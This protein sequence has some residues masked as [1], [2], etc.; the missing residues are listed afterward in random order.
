MLRAVDLS[1]RMG[2]LITN[3]LTD[4][5]QIIF[6]C[7]L[8]ESVPRF[9]KSHADML[10]GYFR[11]FVVES[12][13]LDAPKIMNSNASGAGLGHG[14]AFSN[15]T[16]AMTAAELDLAKLEE[17]V[18]ADTGC[19]VSLVDREWRSQQAPETPVSKIASP[20]RVRGVGASHHETSEFITQR[21]YPPA[22]D[23]NGKSILACLYR[24]LHIVNNLRAKMLIGNDIIGPEGIVI[25]V[26]N[27]QARIGSCN[28][29]AKITPKPRG[30]Y[31]RRKILA[32]N[33]ALVPPRTEMM[34]PTKAVNLPPDRDFIFEPVK[35]ANLTM[36][37]T[38]WTM[39][40]C[41]LATCCIMRVCLNLLQHCWQIM[42][43]YP[44]FQ[45]ILHRIPR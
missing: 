18:R 2:I 16:Y 41:T 35:Q 26:A 17:D 13:H 42:Y 27:K 28:A 19:G 8:N 43:K 7:H 3:R 33:S 24:E 4:T 37:A 30:E 12:S 21:I 31:V 38:L 10:L 15:W 25:D 11:M 6:E 44:V 14:F 5:I 20:L 29:T 23:G 32:E 36:F 22:I 1:T 45:S 40:V 9:L 34:L 39:R